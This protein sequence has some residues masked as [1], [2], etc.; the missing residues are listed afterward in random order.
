MYRQQ[1]RR[2]FVRHPALELHRDSAPKLRR[3]ASADPE[4]RPREV[5]HIQPVR[6]TQNVGLEP[7]SLLFPAP[8]FD[9]AGPVH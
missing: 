5:D 3:A 8:D 7:L 2:P 9:T 6:Q 1:F 4:N